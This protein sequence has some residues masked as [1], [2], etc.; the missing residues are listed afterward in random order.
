LIVELIFIK[1]AINDKIYWYMKVRA[2]GAIDGRILI[3]TLTIL[4][5]R[6]AEFLSVLY[7]FSNFPNGRILIITLSIYRID[8]IDIFN[9]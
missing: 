6:L 4:V 1:E 5:A 2:D 7:R 8:I 9:E 3:S